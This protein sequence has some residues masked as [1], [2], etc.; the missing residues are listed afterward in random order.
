MCF[1]CH[2][3]QMTRACGVRGLSLDCVKCPATKP[4]HSSARE[5]AFLMRMR[6]CLLLDF[7]GLAIVESCARLR[8]AAVEA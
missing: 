4:L 8:S 1:P 2:S 3:G 6:H 5:R 7:S